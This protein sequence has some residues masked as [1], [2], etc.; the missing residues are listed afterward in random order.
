MFEKETKF[1]YDFSMN[2]IKHLGSY[3]TYDQLAGSN[4]HPAIIRYVSAEID[5][6]IFEDRQRI[7][8][9][10][11][12]DYTGEEITRY[13]ALMANEI[14]KNKK[15][16]L[17]YIGNIVLHAI[18]FSLN[19]LAQPNWALVKLIFAKD[20]QLKATE[21]VQIL[22]YVYF[23]SY[24][25]GLVEKYIQKKKLLYVSKDEIEE[26]L[27]KADREIYEN[28]NLGLINN[29]LTAIGDF[30]NIGS[31]NKAKIP[32]LVFELFLKEKK[33]DQYWEKLHSALGTEIKQT[34][35]IPE[36]RQILDSPI[37][38]PAAKKESYI[39]KIL[40]QDKPL[41]IFRKEPNVDQDDE[42]REEEL[43][44]YPP[45]EQKDEDITESN[46]INS[47]APDNDQ[48]EDRIAEDRIAEDNEVLNIPETSE[49]SHIDENYSEDSYKEGSNAGDSYSALSSLD[50]IKSNEIKADEVKTN[51]VK[52][53]DNE[54]I[55]LEI[56]SDDSS[57]EYIF[58][59]EPQDEETWEAAAGFPSEDDKILSERDDAKEEN[60]DEKEKLKENLVEDDLLK[61]GVTEE[62]L[63]EIE[64]SQEDTDIDD[65]Q[66]QLDE[67]FSKAD[68][69]IEEINLSEEN[70]SI[71][72]SNFSEDSNPEISK[73]EN[74]FSE[75]IPVEKVSFS[76]SENFENDIFENDIEEYSANKPGNENELNTEIED[77]DITE[78]RDNNTADEDDNSF[79]DLTEA[80]IDLSDED[81]SVEVELSPTDNVSHAGKLSDTDEFS[82]DDVIF[83][84]LSEDEAESGVGLDLLGAGRKGEQKDLSD[85]FSQ[86]E[87]HK[88]ISSVFNNNIK[89]LV[90]TF[91][92]LSG[93]T[94]MAEAERVF[95]QLYEKNQLSPSSKGIK[96]IKKNLVKYLS[97]V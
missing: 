11:N 70:N 58:L 49:G 19:Y 21:V 27:V 37:V 31:F 62:S 84:H 2:Q 40:N 34:Y 33:L 75:E 50:D 23:Y 30:A 22:K 43:L 64:I 95:N 87:M 54:E 44:K 47:S 74:N 69:D 9:N 24:I 28:Y 3:I 4:L 45:E 12:F 29:V 93:C 15:F 52:A 73:T 6:L 92:A 53:D 97:R 68:R 71:E 81:L 61:A 79:N 65:L 80:G 85:Y 26:L 39:D 18:S 83:A 16:S 1:L 77:Q 51:E 76:E 59:E 90:Q 56:S 36:V 5:Y 82:E 35:E 86:R 42:L 67:Y 55:E 8:S 38:T 48:P 96:L 14:K 66:K 94:D 78:V 89:Q 20:H 32:L 41:S 17:D 63:S 57:E 91:E 13:F 7:I 25:P 46:A 72:E 10:S 88:I 60:S